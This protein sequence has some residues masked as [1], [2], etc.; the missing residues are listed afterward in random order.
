MSC[1]LTS[2][3][4]SIPVSNYCQAF[5]TGWCA[6]SSPAVLKRIYGAE[7][8]EHNNYA[9]TLASVAFAGTIV[10]M[11]SFGFLSDKYGAWL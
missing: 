4:Q 1:E 11:L 7:A 9:T 6:E 10:G 3:L 8:V 5:W 2:L